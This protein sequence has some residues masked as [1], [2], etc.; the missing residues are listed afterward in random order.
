[1][2]SPNAWVRETAARFIREG[3]ATLYPEAVRRVPK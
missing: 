1:L 3:G 2:D